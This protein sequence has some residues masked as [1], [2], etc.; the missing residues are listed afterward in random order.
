MSAKN[1]AILQLYR[2]PIVSGRYCPLKVPSQPW[3]MDL[4]VLIFSVSVKNVNNGFVLKVVFT[5]L[6]HES[7]RVVRYR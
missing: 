1:T 6:P 3:L 2:I 7:F 5:P 4:F